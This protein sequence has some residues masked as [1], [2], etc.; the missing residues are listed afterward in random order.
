MSQY[1]NYFPK[2]EYNKKIA[3]N[4]TR[5]VDFNRTVLADPYA[6]LPYTI[7]DDDRP[8]DVAHYYYGDVAHTWLVYH[9]INAID[10]YY[11][12]PLSYENFN[13]YIIKK[14][15]SMANTTGYEVIDWTQNTT[16]TDNIKHY[17][18]TDDNQDIISVDTFTLDPSINAS[19]WD[20][21]RFYDYETELNDNKR[22]INLLDRK[23]L[24]KA[25]EELGELMI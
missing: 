4:I 17:R 24:S 23:Y 11:D 16:I 15:A 10:P 9:S 18:S 14:Y 1:F 20:A 3:R 2:I 21:I 8:E 6:L 7:L 13:N 12:W 5:R 22:A 25:I 19:E